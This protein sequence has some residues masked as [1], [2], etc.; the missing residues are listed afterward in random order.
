[1][2]D[3]IAYIQSSVL[4]RTI[5]LDKQLSIKFR[6]QIIFVS[7]FAINIYIYIYIYINFVT[8]DN[9]IFSHSYNILK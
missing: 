3:Q 2:S 4:S 9:G 1:M 6:C 7:K 8:E 5:F